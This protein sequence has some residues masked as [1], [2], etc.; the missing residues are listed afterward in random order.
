MTDDGGVASQRVLIAKLRARVAKLEAALQSRRIQTP[1][2]DYELGWNRGLEV[3]A[4]LLRDAL[5]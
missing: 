3:A 2:D 4:L 1:N 5:Q